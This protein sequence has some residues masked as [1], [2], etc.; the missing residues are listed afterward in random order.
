MSRTRKAI[1]T[2]SARFNNVTGSASHSV[3]AIVP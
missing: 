1:G 3:V 2:A